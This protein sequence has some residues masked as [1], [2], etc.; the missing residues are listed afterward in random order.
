MILHWKSEGR[1]REG[2]GGERGEGRGEE[3]RGGEGRGGQG[4]GAEG[5]SLLQ[6]RVSLTSEIYCMRFFTVPSTLWH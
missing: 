5:R 4:G 3:E 2:K 1:G 6:Q